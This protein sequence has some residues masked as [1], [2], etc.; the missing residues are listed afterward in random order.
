[1][2]KL[3]IVEDDI[4]IFILLIV[5]VFFVGGLLGYILKIALEV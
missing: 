1:M 3:R 2:K 4:L 5:C